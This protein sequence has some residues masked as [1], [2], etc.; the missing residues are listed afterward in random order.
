MCF[1][2]T[3]FSLLPPSRARQKQLRLYKNTKVLSGPI[4]LITLENNSTDAM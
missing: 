4:Q 3:H 2:S 1:F